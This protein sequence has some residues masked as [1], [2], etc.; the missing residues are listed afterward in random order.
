MP[1]EIDTPII[2]LT[3]DFGRRDHYV[4][5]MKGVIFQ[6]APRA[7][8]IDVTHE[9]DPQNIPGAAF[10]L[11]QVLAWYPPDTIH[12]VVV[13]PG[14]GTNRD[15]IAARYARQT[16]IAP[17]N[18][19]VSLVHQSYKIEAARI[20]NNPQ[21]ALTQVS[22]TF[23][24]RDIIAPAAAHLAAGVSFNDLGTPTDHLEILQ[25]AR[26]TIEDH[27][28]ITGQ[29]IHVDR[30]GNLITN[31]SQHDLDGVLDSKHPATVSLD[32][33]NFGH[34]RATYAEVTPGEALALVGST[35]FLEVAVHLGNAKDTLNADI[36]A[37][38]I[39]ER[40]DH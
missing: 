11:G 9:I 4:A 12:V 20:V 13:D 8:V 36:G 23:H 34:L 35:G 30:F 37:K 22:N 10:V 15:I 38:V 26:P 7:R 18:G 3:T 1:P 28:R 17:D 32:D 19:I 6:I 27:K 21:L 2:T 14:V 5:S 33:Q 40:T 24:G 39:V 16:I 31:I 29:V 25:L